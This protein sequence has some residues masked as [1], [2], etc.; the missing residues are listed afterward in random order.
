MLRRIRTR[1]RLLAPAIALAAM[2]LSAW[3]TGLALCRQADGCLEVE[4]TPLSGHFAGTPDSAGCVSDHCHAGEH[5]TGHAPGSD[6]VV[7]NDHAA[8]GCLD[9]AMSSRPAIGAAGALS[10]AL[11][12]CGDAAAPAGYA[13]EADAGGIVRDSDGSPP[14]RSP[15][16]TVVRSVVRLC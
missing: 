2:L 6:L 4:L 15:A 12:A 10:H 7:V 5:Q 8:A 3:P 1:C 13:I 16:L 14:G 9:F 11:I